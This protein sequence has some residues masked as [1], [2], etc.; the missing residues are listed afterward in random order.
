M[1]NAPRH[2]ASAWV[3]YDGGN[4]IRTGGGIRYVGS[5]TDVSSTIELDSF[6]LVDL[7]ATYTRGNVEA[8]LNVSNLTDEVYLSTCGWFGCYYGEGRTVTAKVACKW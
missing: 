2:M 4:G 1:W 8:T 3:D 7:G 6:T 5:R